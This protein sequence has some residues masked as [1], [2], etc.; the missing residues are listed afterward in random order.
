MSVPPIDRRR[1]IQGFVVAGPVLAVAARLALD[2]A[3]AESADADG[4]GT[5]EITN[6]FDGTDLAITN[7]RPFYYDLRIEVTK[8]A[9]DVPVV[10][11]VD[12][13][14]LQ[15]DLGHGETVARGAH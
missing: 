6:V 10:G 2:G 12:D 1:F 8:E 9:P 15:Q 5:P 4:F 13:G 3:L 11:D 7:G 14:G